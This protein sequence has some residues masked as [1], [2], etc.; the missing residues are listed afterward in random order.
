VGIAT[1]YEATRRLTNIAAAT[2]AA[3]LLALA[4]LQLQCGLMTM[5]DGPAAAASAL[6]ALVLVSHAPPQLLGL[7]AGYACSMR[8]G[9]FPLLAGTGLAAL[10]RGRAATVRAALGAAVGLAPSIATFA[11]GWSRPL[12][13]YAFWRPEIFGTPANAFGLRYVTHN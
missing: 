11:G 5:S 1:V 3:S 13:G 6:W 7:V 9:A 12:A 8:I 4:P 2:W 10:S